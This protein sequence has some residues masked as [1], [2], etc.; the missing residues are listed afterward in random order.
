MMDPFMMG[1]MGMQNGFNFANQSGADQSMMQE[2]MRQNQATIEQ[3]QAMMF[4]M[5]QQMVSPARSPQRLYGRARLKDRN[6]FAGHGTAT[7]LHD[8]HLGSTSST[9][10]QTYHLRSKTRDAH[11]QP[12]VHVQTRRW[13]FPS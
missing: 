13:W 8:D 3:M 4:Q 7:T 6:V 12:I 9:A 11:Q 10:R 1:M 5:A 2:M